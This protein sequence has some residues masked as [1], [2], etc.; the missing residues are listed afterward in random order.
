MSEPIKATIEV[1]VKSLQDEVKELQ[2]AKSDTR[3]TREDLEEFQGILTRR[4]K[5]IEKENEKWMKLMLNFNSVMKMKIIGNSQTRS[6]FY[7]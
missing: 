6:D 4:I 2:E 1:L 3:T 7:S 5:D